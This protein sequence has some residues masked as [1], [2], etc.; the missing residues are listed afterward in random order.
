MFRG[1]KLGKTP[2]KKLSGQRDDR[3]KRGDMQKET[4]LEFLFETYVC[5]PFWGKVGS[6][7][8]FWRGGPTRCA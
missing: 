4:E 1:V 6:K 3:I 2:K 5:Q 7:L 8:F